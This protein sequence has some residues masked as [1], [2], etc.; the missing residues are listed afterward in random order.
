[1][2]NVLKG[3]KQIKKYFTNGSRR[4]RITL[5]AI[6]DV[7]LSDFTFHEEYL[8]SIVNQLFENITLA[9]GPSEIKKK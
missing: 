7:R 2:I 6:E 1:M 9:K 3:N 4:W 8:T 5:A